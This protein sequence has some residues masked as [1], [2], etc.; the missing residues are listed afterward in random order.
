MTQL[1]TSFGIIMLA[2][3]DGQ[4]RV[5]SL[6][7]FFRHF[8]SHRIEVVERRTRFD[9]ARAEAR[10]HILEGFRIALANLDTV[11]EQ[12]KAAATPADARA[13]LMAEHGLSEVQAKE[14]LEMRLQRLTGM[15]QQKIQDEYDEVMRRIAE[16]RAILADREL[17]L[18]IIREETAEVR[19]KYTNARR[20]QI[21]GSA[22][23][24]NTEDLIAEEDMVVT[25]SNNGYIKRLPVS[26]YRQQRRGGRGVA[27]M[28]TK[29]EDFVKDL[30][31]ASTHDYMLF[32]T[33]TGRLYWRKVHELPKAS[34]T[35][36]GRNM[37]NVLSLKGDE[38]VTAF[39]PVRDLHE[40]KFVLMVTEQGIVKKTE[41]RHFSNPRSTGIIA[42]DLAEGDGL[43]EVMLTSG[44]DNVLI[45]TYKGMA[46]RFPESDVRPMGRT[47]RGVIGIKLRKDDH[48]I[49]VSLAGDDMT[50]LSVSENGFG[51][52]TQ[53]SEY[54]LQ[55]RGGQGI[56]NMKT[57]ARNGN[58]IGMLTVDD[59][60]EIVMVSTS[61]IVIRSAVKDIRTIGRNTQGVKLM[62]PT[63]GARVSAVA[64]AVG[65]SKEK[66][67]TEEEAPS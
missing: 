55:H 9:L 14:I 11:I 19:D 10:A 7:Q 17:V 63:E 64:R 62:S 67:V 20:T 32:F 31:I 33:N 12:I 3:V 29:D 58:V 1:Q 37:A 35:A 51:K 16:Y 36:R 13:V 27:G 60:D 41:L 25:V 40:E 54:R 57:T 44:E 21:L 4:P 28:E 56:I 2:V 34:R 43:I 8:L 50:V 39:L 23:D 42:L 66:K 65:E 15:E 26:T 6:P 46:I 18:D 24:I 5:L 22:E 52:R 38:R 53:I 59:R 47:A 48:V 49:G 30:F 45:A 61:G